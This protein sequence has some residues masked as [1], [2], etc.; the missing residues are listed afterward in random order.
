MK[1]R[2]REPKFMSLKSSLPRRKPGGRTAFTLIELLVVIAI[3]AILAAMLLPALSKAK[4]KAQGVQCMSNLKQLNLAW[5]LYAGDYNDR[6]VFNSIVG[7]DEGWCAGWLS[8]AANV[9]DN[10][11]VA[12]LMP[13]KGKLWPYNKAL[14]IYKCPAD[15]SVAIERNAAYPR[16]RSVSMNIRMNGSDH[17]VA[18]VKDFNNPGKY[19]EILNPPPSKAF[20]FIDEREDSIDDGAFGVDM[21]HVGA[22]I[23]IINYPASYHNGAGGL[24]FADGHAEIKKWLDP[25]TKPPIVR[26]DYIP[27]YGTSPN[28][29]D[30]AWLQE[31]CS[32][33]R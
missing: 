8:P 16:V 12:N 18:P 10:T 13:P 29:P 31:R 19:G 33:H 7:N 2:V 32:A 21:V 15:T 28:N 5:Y 30:I 11:N 4:T 27:T 25:R 20:V 23:T 3:I 24:S 14:G 1:N 6:L 26:G 17:F 22:A 9:R